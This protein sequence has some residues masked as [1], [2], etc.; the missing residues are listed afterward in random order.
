MTDI[1]KRDIA[2]P[3][4]KGLDRHDPAVKHDKAD[5]GRKHSKDILSKRCYS[6]SRSTQPAESATNTNA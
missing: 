6:G 5:R 4:R 1:G 3:H 2:Q